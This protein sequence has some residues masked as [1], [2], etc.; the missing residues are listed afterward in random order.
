MQGVHGSQFDKFTVTIYAAC[1]VEGRGATQHADA[2]PALRVTQD[3][4]KRGWAFL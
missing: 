3:K 1:P 4:L 2:V